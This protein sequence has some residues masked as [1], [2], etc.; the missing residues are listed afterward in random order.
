MTG[1]QTCA[2]PIS[3][4]TDHMSSEYKEEVIKYWHQYTKKFKPYWHKYYSS[5][6]GVYDVRYIPDDLYYTTIDQYFNNRKYGWGVNDKNYYSIWFSNA[7]QPK[8]IV[9]KING[10]YYNEKYELISKKEVIQL[11]SQQPR[12]IIKPSVETGGSKGIKFWEKSQGINLLETYLIQGLSNL[13]VQ[14]IIVQHKNL[15]ENHSNSINTVRVISL[16][17]KNKVHILSS[18]LRMG[19]NGS[20]V[21]NASAGGITCGIKENGQLKDVAYSAHGIKYEKHPQ[22]FVFSDCIVPS[23]EKVKDLVIMEHSKMAHFRLISWDIAVG[24]DGEPIFIEANLRNGEL[25]FHQFNNGPLF[26]DLT[27]EVLSEVFK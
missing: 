24:E 23:Y 6:N 22:G 8:T 2:L 26:G 17:F 12:L 16:L 19:V 3:L 9:R 18:V 13:I 14:E 1:V 27:D 21:D 25:D 10:I 15:S 4:N 5:R 7:K 20:T 11:C